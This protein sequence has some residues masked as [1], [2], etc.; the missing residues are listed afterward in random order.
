ME[1]EPESLKKTLLYNTKFNY[2]R[3]RCIINTRCD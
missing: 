1:Y 3:Q 2:Y